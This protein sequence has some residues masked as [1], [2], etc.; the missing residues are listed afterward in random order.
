MASNRPTQPPLITGRLLALPRQAGVHYSSARVTRNLALLALLSLAPAARAQPFTPETKLLLSEGVLRGSP[1]LLGI[2]GAFVGVAEGAEGITRNPAAAASKSPYFESDFNVDFGAALHFLPPWAVQDQDW[3]NDG[4]LDQ[5]EAQGGPFSF[6]GTQVLYLAAS[7]QYKAVGL[8]LGVDFQN[9]LAK[10][11]REGQPFESYFNL[12]LAHAFGSL[13]LSVWDDQILLGIGAESTHAFF[14]YSE[15]AQGATLPSP[16]DSLGYH[17]WGVQLGG[18][19]RPKNEDYRVGFSF[20]PQTDGGPVAQRTDIGGLVPFA[21]IVAP[22]RLSLGASWA[23]G[24]GRHYNITSPAGWMQLPEPHPDGSPA[25]TPAM[26][27]WLITTQ[28]DVFFPVRNATYVTAFLEQDKGASAVPAGNQ[29]S[30]EPR[31]A[32]EKEVFADRLRLRLGGYLE[33]PLVSSAPFVRPH[34]TF[35]GEVYLF[36]LGP[37]RISFGLSFDLARKYQNLSVAFLVWK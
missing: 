27:K 8:G 37:Q 14:I 12:N 28:L 21:S 15:Q 33:P 11:T 26:T 3:D 20:R 16:K 34:V 10:T 7:L 17:G 35:G 5:V 18:L 22:A 30:F 9:F 25:Y 2:A 31:A 32:V 24:S 6:L 29:L 19:W 23:L 4:R 13:G 36:K 1:R